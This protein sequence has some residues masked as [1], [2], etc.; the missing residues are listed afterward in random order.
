[1]P[2]SYVFK[3]D[4]TTEARNIRATKDIGG[5]SPGRY[6]TRSV[7][8]DGRWYGTCKDYPCSNRDCHEQGYVAGHVWLDGYDKWNRMF[9]VPLCSTCN[10]NFSLCFDVSF[11]AYAAMT[12]RQLQ[13]LQSC[14]CV[15]GMV[16]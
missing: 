3:L 6:W 12:I 11:L 7:E 8:A 9:L 10:N 1:M 14:T 2:S 13:R 4:S 15:M 5:G 16:T